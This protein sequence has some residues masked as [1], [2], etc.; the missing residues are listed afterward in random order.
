LRGRIRVVDTKEP[1]RHHS[2]VGRPSTKK[3]FIRPI[4]TYQ[5]APASASEEDVM[6][7]FV[8]LFVMSGFAIQ[9]TTVQSGSGAAAGKRAVGACSLLTK[10]LVTQVTPYEKQVLDVVTQIPPSEDPVGPSGSACEY[11]GIGLQ[12]DPFGSPARI[13]KEFGTKWERVADVGDVAYFRNNIGRWGELY[14]RAGAHV[15]TIQM[16]VPNGRT[17]ESIKPNTIALAKAIL[18]KLK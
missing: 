14:V 9:A 17:A 15:L 12:I 2:R 11:G 7:E 8:L 4:I 1:H 16:A 6:R 10:E 13:E 3:A 18:P 5:S